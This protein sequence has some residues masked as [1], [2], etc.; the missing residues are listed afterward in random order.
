VCR[1]VCHVTPSISAFLQASSN[2]N[3]ALSGFPVVEDV[4]VLPPQFPELQNPA[5]FRIDRNDPDFLSLV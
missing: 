2:L 3:K 4:F 1:N 5:H